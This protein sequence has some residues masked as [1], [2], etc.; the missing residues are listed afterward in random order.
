MESSKPLIDL[1]KRPKISYE[2]FNLLKQK[3]IINK[4]AKFICEE[5]IAKSKT[6]QVVP[7]DDD[8]EEILKD[9]TGDVDQEE[10]WE[11]ISDDESDLEDSLT[12]KCIYVAKEVKCS[13][14]SDIND[15]DTAAN[16]IKKLS[17]FDPLAWL[18]KRSSGLVQLLGNLCNI[19]VNVAKNNKLILLCKIIE[20]IYY[21]NNSK[22]VLS[23]YFLEN[24]L[25][26]SFTNS[27]SCMTFMGNRS[28]EVHT[29]T[30]LSG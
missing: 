6:V 16:S 14:S 12:L 3:G 28:P 24:L 21:C 18:S 19:D 11:D 10:M 15:V 2:D 22:K 4:G 29:L 8:H 26:Y 9:T 1:I 5:C 7:E 27:K 20:L 23:C 25:C 13:I 30:F 17:D